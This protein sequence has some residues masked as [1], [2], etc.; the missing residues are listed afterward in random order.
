MHEPQAYPVPVSMRLWG[1]VGRWD[2][3]DRQLEIAGRLGRRAL[4]AERVY[5]AKLGFSLQL[6]PSDP[7]QSAMAAGLFSRHAAWL[8][9]RYA[10]P[11]TTAIDVGAHLGYFTLHLAR[12]VGP[13]GAVHAFEPDPRLYPR[14]TSHIELNRAP[15]VTANHHGLLDRQVADHEFLIPDQLGWASAV[16][17]AGEGVRSMRVPMARLDDYVKAQGI[18]ASDVSFIKV[19]VEG[20]ELEVLHGAQATLSAT[21]A[22]VLVEHVPRRAEATGHRAGDVPAFMR[23]LGFEPFVP[24]R[25]WGHFA[26]RPG[27]EP[28]V[29]LDVLFL[30]SPD[31][32]RQRRSRGARPRPGQTRPARSHPWHTA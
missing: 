29:G 23:E 22:A 31:R 30:R 14:L 16:G 10:R 9:Q 17:E 27:A 21:S 19:D 15:W 24:V 5:R 2:R 1:A 18:R 7:F 3:P 6:D 32:A 13:E 8:M 25:S 28:V 4:R 12:L 20:S 26:L 11:G